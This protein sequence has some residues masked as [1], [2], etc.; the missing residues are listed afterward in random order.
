MARKTDKDP[1]TVAEP[2][3]TEPPATESVPESKPGSAL[4]SGPATSDP[5]PEAEP[6]A[7]TSE[8]AVAEIPPPPVEDD[9]AP[10]ASNPEPELPPTT[11][12]SLPASVVVRRGGF[13]PMVLGGIVAAGLGFAAAW[14]WLRDDTADD[15]AAISAQVDANAAALAEIR[16][17]VDSPRP[18]DLSPVQDEIAALRADTV[19][20]IDSL[21]PA[22]DDLARRVEAIERAPS[23]DGTLS[24]TA[25]AAWAAELDAIRADIAAQ[26]DQTRA[27]A[28][29]A[30]AR[31]DATA[32][33]VAQI[34]ANA[35][36][37]AERAARRA[38]L[39]LVLAALETGGPFDAPLA[40]AVAADAAP[41]TLAALSTEGAPTMA[42][43][44][45]GFP[46]AARAALTV[47]RAEGLAGDEGGRVLGFLRSTL[48]VRSTVPREGD[49]PDAILSRAEAALADGRLPDTLAEIAALPEVV[50]AA[51]GDWLALAESR[52]A[53]L[54]EAAALSETLND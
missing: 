42:M 51:M 10:R 5:T 28:E 21:R 33:E 8:P 52:T 34:E 9:E 29:A 12:D 15:V 27:L 25:L 47:A 48:D 35:A 4:E 43:L 22:L 6:A 46:A 44:R 32:T 23:A 38:A 36:A 18:P 45:E 39:S 24:D 19:A 14:W 1:E 41:P 54:A 31:V 30:A 7:T 49:D 2:I 16:A 3:A 40:E 20:Q 50:R 53:A 13:I 11:P 26:Q 17:Q 37:A